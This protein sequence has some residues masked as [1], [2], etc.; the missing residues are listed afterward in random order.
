[1]K[2]SQL[3]GALLATTL[4]AGLAGPA[5]AG[6]INYQ[7]VTFTTS[8]QGNVLTLEVD[9][10]HRTGDWSTASTIGALELKG[11]GTFSSVSATGPSGAT[12]WSLSSQLTSQGCKGGG[13]GGS[14]CYSGAHIALA[15]DM[16]FQFTFNNT[17]HPFDAPQIKVNF[18][19]GDDTRKVGSVQPVEP[20]PVPVPGDA[21]LPEPGSVAL[22]FGGMLAM[23]AFALSRRAR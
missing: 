22:L 5:S 13:N 23:G 21:P 19:V 15:D 20:V 9:A 6:I 2:L 4:A 1:M 14:L 10:A 7:G 16:I 8:T 18:F 12:G 3:R 11:L 17:A